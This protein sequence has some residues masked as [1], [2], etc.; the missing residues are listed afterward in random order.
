[1]IVKRRRISRS[2]GPVRGLVLAG[3]LVI[4]ACG[5]HA[6]GA[7]SV[8]DQSGPAAVP[9]SVPRG[10]WPTFAYDSQRSGVGPADTGITASNLPRLRLRQ[11]RI[12]GIADSAAIELGAVKVRGRRRDLIAVTTTYG[13]TIALDARTGA[14]LWEF[15]PGGVHSTPGNP[16]VTTASPTADPSRRSLY[17]ASPDGVIHKLSVADGRQ[18]WARSITFDPIH[19]KL[20][21]SLNVSGRFVVAVTGGYFGDAPPYDAH[22]VTLDRATGRIVHV[23]NT[24]CSSRHQLIRAGS[25]SVT[26][27]RGG[28]AIWSRAGAVIEPGSGKILVA[29]GNGPFDGSA[30]WGDSVLELSP[31]ASRLLHNW[32]PTNQLALDHTDTDVGS[33]SPALLPRYRGLR[34]AVQSGK[35]GKL[36]LLNLVRLNGSRGVA[37]QRLGGEL[38]EVNAPGGSA[39]F[40]APAVS[41]A[42]GRVFVFVANDSG[43]AGYELVGGAHPRLQTVWQNSTSATS[44]VLAGGLLYLYDEQDGKLF[45]RRP[46]SGA[47]LRSLPAGAGHWNSPIV[48]GGRIIVPTGSYHSSS[49]T[50]TL[51]IYHLPGR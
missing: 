46:G 11:V 13:R 31:D 51:E 5:G 32:T 45:I 40:T 8:T 49:A 12:N 34:L 3:A 6:A 21:S 39:V 33:T 28:S 17:S 50:S 27:T 29:T 42:G 16:Q 26:N 9:S 15:T 20:A 14:R 48:V 4:V 2:S 19:E 35:D 43:S 1:M 18:L 37:G 41:R 24:E 47:L 10:D 36:H 23:W 30:S 22:V 7:S 44:P 25:C 38:G